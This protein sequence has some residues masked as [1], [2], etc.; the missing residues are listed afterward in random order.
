MR[1]MEAAVQKYPNTTL[2]FNP[3]QGDSY[4]E[5]C[6]FLGISLEENPHC[7]LHTFPHKTK[8]D[9]HEVFVLQ[10]IRLGVDLVVIVVAVMVLAWVLGRRRMQNRKRGNKSQ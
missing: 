5:L 7:K 10:S 4:P 1:D 9:A 2:V 3:K 6:R 8:D